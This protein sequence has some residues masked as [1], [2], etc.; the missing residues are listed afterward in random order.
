[1]KPLNAE[2][3]PPPP[4]PTCTH[5]PITALSRLA[6]GQEAIERAA[7]LFRALGDG[8]RL[9]IL[10]LLVAGEVCVGEVVT[11]FG[12]KFS[13]VSQRLR[14]LRTEGLVTRRRDGAHVFYALADA[15]VKDLVTNALAHAT[16]LNGPSR[17]TQ[18]EDDE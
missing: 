15:H 1:M 17:P 7:R 11:A 10:N 12:E 5:N 4:M 16:E 2:P 6:E 13:T 18:T 3:D 8:P 9:R 14:V